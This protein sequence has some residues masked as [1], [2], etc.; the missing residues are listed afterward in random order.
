MLPW[1][2]FRLIRAIAECGGLTRAAAQLGINHSTAFRRLEGIEAMIEARLFERHRSGYVPTPAGEAMAAA[3]ARMETEAARFDHE[4]ATRAQ[5]PSGELRITAPVDLA[6]DLLMP[7]LARFAERYPAIRL[8][9][10]VTPEPL[11]LSRR[12]AD[13]ALRATS[14]PPTNL[15]GR[16]LSGLAWAIYGRADQA[17][18]TPPSRRWVAPSPNV[19]DGRFAAIVA[20]RAGEEPV[21]LRLNT[22]TGLRE[23]VRAGLGIGPV[24][25]FLGDA[26]PDLRRLGGIEPD[27]AT[28]LWLLTHP[29]LR[30]AMRVRVFMD[31]MAE[32]IAPLRPA[33]EGRRAA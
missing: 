33:L 23:A 5:A 20:E 29:D 1:D 12:D 13:V 8:D 31:F 17:D 16:R 6:T 4:L 11:N 26:C 30:Q 24:P 27:L 7:P 18:L 21:A 32:A 3:A 28:D 22:V 10:V 19:G 14:A 9:L 25:C 2:D 15:V